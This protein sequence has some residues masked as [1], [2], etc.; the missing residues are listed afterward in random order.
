[1]LILQYLSYGFKFCFLV[2]AKFD[3]TAA[4]TAA[5]SNFKF[6]S[7]L[8]DHATTFGNS[9]TV[10][11]LFIVITAAPFSILPS[12]GEFWDFDLFRFLS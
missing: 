11:P 1:M 3:H 9:N 5:K 7:N 4:L 10:L 8:S 6:M 12:S 2:V